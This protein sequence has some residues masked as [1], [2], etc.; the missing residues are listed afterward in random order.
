MSVHCIKMCYFFLLPSFQ[1]DYDLL[2]EG[3]YNLYSYWYIQC[4]NDARVRLEYINMAGMSQFKLNLSTYIE[5]SKQELETSHVFGFRNLPC[6]SLILIGCQMNF[7]LAV[8][9]FDGVIFVKSLC[10]ISLIQSPFLK[11]INMLYGSPAFV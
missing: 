8:A 7:D 5:K 4:L 3:G 1:Q 2:E 11:C 10:H 6:F 9:M